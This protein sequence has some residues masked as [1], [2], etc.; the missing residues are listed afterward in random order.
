MKPKIYVAGP[1]TAPTI[2][3]CEENSKKAI[4]ASLEL[5]KKGYIPFVPH[6]AHWA[7]LRAKET[8]VN[9]SWE[10][11]MAWD[12]EFLKSCDAFLYLGP[13]RGAD[14]ELKIAKKLGLKIYYSLEE[15]PDINKEDWRTWMKR[16]FATYGIYI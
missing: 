1:Y 13:S 7:D 4:D 6:L 8:G 9:M 3:Q 15:V 10:D 2:E 16:E 12:L 11:Y 5:F 14:I